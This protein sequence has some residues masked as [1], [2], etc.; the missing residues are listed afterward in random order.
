MTPRRYVALLRA[1]N[2]GGHVVKMQALREQ[3][4]ALGFSSV[5]TVIAS[6]NVIFDAP[7]SDT[8]AL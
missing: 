5:A 7:T 2:V 8:E 3:F 4:E 1:I 6:G